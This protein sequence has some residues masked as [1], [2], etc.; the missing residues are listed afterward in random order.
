MVRIS[1][2]V[3]PAVSRL[4]FLSGISIGM[5]S[6]DDPSA[7]AVS[8]RRRV[9]IV[10]ILILGLGVA[11]PHSVTVPSV[12][13]GSPGLQFGLEALEI[14]LPALQPGFQPHSCRFDVHP[15]LSL[16]V[17]QNPVQGFQMLG[18]QSLQQGLQRGGVVG[19]TV[20]PFVGPIKTM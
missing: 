2:S 12:G 4:V 5:R 17:G 1:T 9:A 10:A 18:L 7:G 19:P 8:T 6:G 16:G 20:R 15:C 14:G 11:R 13:L 3:S